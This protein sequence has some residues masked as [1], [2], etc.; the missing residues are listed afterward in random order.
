[1]N[2]SA[3]LKWVVE[4]AAEDP[5]TVRS[6]LN[7]ADYTLSFG[8]FEKA[9]DDMGL[10]A[11]AGLNTALQQKAIEEEER[12]KEELNKKTYERASQRPSE[13]TFANS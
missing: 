1:M 9:S 5:L 4:T 10:I 7:K 12:R 2:L 3:Y 6:V 13:P 8:K 11:N